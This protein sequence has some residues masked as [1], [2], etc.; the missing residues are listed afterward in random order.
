[1][2]KP[3][4]FAE[5]RRLAPDFVLAWTRDA[6]GLPEV[7]ARCTL[8]GLHFTITHSQLTTSAEAAEIAVMHG[9]LDAMEMLSGEAAAEVSR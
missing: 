4:L 7:Q 9:M 8:N 5:C 3:E 2:T 1:M 6:R